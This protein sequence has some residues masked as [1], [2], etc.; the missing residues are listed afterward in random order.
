MNQTSV[1]IVVVVIVA[2]GGFI[3]VQRQAAMRARLTNEQRIG[4][5]VGDLVGGIIGLATSGDGDGG[6]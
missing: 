6:G 2:I 4:R 3:L 1:A 5:G